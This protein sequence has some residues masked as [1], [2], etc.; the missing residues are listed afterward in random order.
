MNTFA[1]FQTTYH[2]A[3]R[4]FL[5]LGHNTPEAKTAANRLA[6]LEESNPE[7]AEQAEANFGKA[8]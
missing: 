5:G 2:T 6:D 3:L 8:V 1:E 7:W 4:A